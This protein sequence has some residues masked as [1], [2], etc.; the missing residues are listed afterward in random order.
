MQ[1]FILIFSRFIFFKK[2]E[3]EF[4][5]K[6]TTTNQFKS[7][8]IITDQGKEEENQHILMFNQFNNKLFIFR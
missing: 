7:Q 3:Q 1:H 5:P 8:F 2:K 4:Q 6:K